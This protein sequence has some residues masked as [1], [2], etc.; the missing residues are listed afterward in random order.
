MTRQKFKRI[1]SNFLEYGRVRSASIRPKPITNE[2]INEINV[3]AYFNA[4][5]R[6][7]IRSAVQDLGLT[8]Y[9]VQAILK[10]HKMHDYSFTTVQE[11]H[12]HDDVRRLEF[13][14]Q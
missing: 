8:F 2:E 12:P 3:F 13:C 1:E 5:P 6:Q 11:L 9:A 4:Y 14:E 10:K 7:S